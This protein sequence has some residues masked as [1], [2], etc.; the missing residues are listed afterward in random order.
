MKRAIVLLVLSVFSVGM[1]SGCNT[2]AGAG[3]DV[4]GAGEKVED[5]AR[6]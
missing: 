2:V 6:R 1:L 3:K 5:A 4:Q